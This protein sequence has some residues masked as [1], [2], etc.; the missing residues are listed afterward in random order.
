[1]GHIMRLISNGRLLSFARKYWMRKA[2]YNTL[3]HYVMTT[4]KAV[5]FL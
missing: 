4:I 3:V 1:V 2:E 5:N